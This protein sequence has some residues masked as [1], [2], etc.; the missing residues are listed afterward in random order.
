MTSTALSEA[1]AYIGVTYSADSIR[2]AWGRG[3]PRQ[4]AE[5]FATWLAVN[6]QN[7]TAGVT[8]AGRA[9]GLA[10]EEVS[11]HLS[12]DS[13]ADGCALLAELFRRVGASYFV[14][15]SAALYMAMNAAAAS[16]PGDST[17][18]DL[19]PP[20]FID[21][22]FKLTKALGE[23]LWLA[24][25]ISEKLSRAGYTADAE[26]W[27]SLARTG[28]GFSNLYTIAHD[29]YTKFQALPEDGGKSTAPKAQKKRN[30]KK[31]AS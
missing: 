13:A 14:T 16:Q 2:K 1:L 26:G 29:A 23:L 10:R 5:A 9:V 28:Q 20:E 6:S 31:G 30:P 22:H 12:L 15:A 25:A 8:S 24:P 17:V 11:G 19:V 18:G 27:L 21:A 7:K 4:S 3:A